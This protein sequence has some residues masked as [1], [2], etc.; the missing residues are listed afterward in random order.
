VVFFPRKNK[1]NF[2]LIGAISVPA[3]QQEGVCTGTSSK[4][5]SVIQTQSSSYFIFPLLRLLQTEA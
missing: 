3:T 5:V 2:H 1:H 4:V